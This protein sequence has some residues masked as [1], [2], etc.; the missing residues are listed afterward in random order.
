MFEQSE[1]KVPGIR[2]N[3]TNVFFGKVLGSIRDVTSALFTLRYIWCHLILT[4]EIYCV[5][6]SMMGAA[7]S[8]FWVECLLVKEKLAVQI[9]LCP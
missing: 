6:L 5:P 2:R 8:R 1:N 3:D 9:L 4:M 7:I